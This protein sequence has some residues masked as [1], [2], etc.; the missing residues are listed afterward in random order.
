M[1]KENNQKY[2]ELKL[3]TVFRDQIEKNIPSQTT[4]NKKIQIYL[5]LL[6][7]PCLRILILI[8]ILL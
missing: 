6:T 1:N 4:L 7:T 3:A 5:A 2:L 8:I